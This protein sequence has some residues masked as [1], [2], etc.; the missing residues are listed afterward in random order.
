MTILRIVSLRKVC[1]AR[2]TLSNVPL[3]YA[4]PS[5]VRY[6]PRRNVHQSAHRE[7]TCEWVLPVSA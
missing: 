4:P 5:R 2:H 3:Q 7:R 6:L 1:T